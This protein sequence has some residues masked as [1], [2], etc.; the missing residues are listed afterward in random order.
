VPA[1]AE[2]VRNEQEILGRESGPVGP[3]RNHAA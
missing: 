2:K 1:P 3:S